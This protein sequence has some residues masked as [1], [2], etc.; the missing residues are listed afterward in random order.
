VPVRELAVETG[1]L[2]DA[3][4]VHEDVDMPTPRERLV[5]EGVRGRRIGEVGRQGVGR[6]AEL[7]GEVGEPPLAA[8][9]MDDDGRSVGDER[10]GC[11]G[12]DPSGRAGDEDNAFA[13][14]V[15]SAVLGRAYE[16][17]PQASS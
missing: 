12:T 13:V 7:G 16:A 1:G 4:V 10:A 14:G 15:H 9:V 3:R 2:V 6:V 17:E 8:K 5:P 11:R